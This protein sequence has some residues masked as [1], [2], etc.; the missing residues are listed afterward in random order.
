MTHRIVSVIPMKNMVLLVGFQNGVEKT[1]DMRTLY[2]VFPQFKVFEKDIELFNRVQVDMGGYGISW[3]DDL[4][5]DAEEIWEE[6][7]EV[8]KKEA[9]VVALLAE[10][11]IKARDIVGMTQKQ[12]SESTGI[13][14]ADISK[15]ERG[16]AN[17]SLFT[18]KRLAEGLG[19]KL[20]IEFEK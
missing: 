5:L 18:L 13:Y 11:L 9:D 3:N 15:I 7:I 17:P 19:L 16:L 10:S 1:Y 12:L 2:P 8:S 14:Q 4:D 6:G 20:R